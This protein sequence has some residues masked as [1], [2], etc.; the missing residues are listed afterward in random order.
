V[1]HTLIENSGV[2]KATYALAYEKLT[3]AVPGVQPSTDGR[4]DPE[5]MRN[6]FVANHEILTAAAEGRLIEVLAEAGQELTRE[7]LERGYAL[8]GILGA[9]KALAETQIV[10]Q[11]ALTGNIRP[12]AENKLMLLGA[13]ASLL[14]MEVGGFG[15]DHIVRS[16]LVRG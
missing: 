8:P 11:S 15:S 13:S 12:N 6:L 1:D 16:R 14:D 10:V 2:S 9:L 5:I 3:G 7:L 4:T